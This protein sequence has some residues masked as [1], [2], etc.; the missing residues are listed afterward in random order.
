MKSFS[1]EAIA[2]LKS[3]KVI[4]V[5]AV[6]L[7]TAT[8]VRLWGGHGPMV[9]DGQAFVGIGDAGLIEASGG[10]LGGNAQGAQLTLSK[11]D[12]DVI[13]RVDLGA[14]RGV[15]VILWRLLFNGSGSQL[16]HASVFLRG[17]VDRASSNEI[18]GGT[19]SLIIGVEGAARGLGRRLERMRTDADQRLIDPNDGSFR[20]VSYA[21]QKLVSWGG[22]PPERAGAAFGGQT[23]VDL[24]GMSA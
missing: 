12:P 21:G 20:R 4:S 14:L 1:A 15:P 8:P 24:G 13:A 11:V 16:L 2:A 10:A 17:R 5:G 3:G 23:Y 7:G 9:I 18:P 22:K 19:A 6:Y